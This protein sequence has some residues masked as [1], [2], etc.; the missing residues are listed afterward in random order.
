MDG[1]D[2]D[3]LKSLRGAVYRRDGSVVVELLRGRLTYD[4]LQL[5]GDGLFDAITQGV[6]GA[7]ELA[8]QCAVALRERWW[9][10]DEELA[11]Q[12]EAA[13]G[14]GVTPLL[15]PL[16]VDLE[17]LASHMEGDPM[18]GGCRINLE[19]GECWP[20]SDE[21]QD[22]EQDDEEEDDEDR[23]LYVE[24]VGSRAGY[25]DMEV[26]IATVRDPD[27]ADR[28]EIAIDG[29]GAFHRFKDVLS[30]W[31]EELAR[32]Y[33]ISGERQRGRARACLADKGYRPVGPRACT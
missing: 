32:Y 28:L 14:R 19:T 31:P 10:G 21:L 12:L 3:A 30:R 33:Q 15:R 22:D 9:D 17:E 2:A 18:W 5:S 16:P 13:T 11:D 25:R 8:A 26:F 24:P 7:N 29:R 23:W 1:W 27:I 6:E 20:W 4:V